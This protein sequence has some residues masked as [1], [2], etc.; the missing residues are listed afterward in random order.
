MEISNCAIPSVYLAPMAGFT[1]R[2][3]REVC[4][5]FFD[6]IITTEMVS[7]SALY[8]GDNKTKVLM[9]GAENQTLQLFGANPEYISRIA[10]IINEH[11][12]NKIEINM[13]C[14]M[15]KIVKN[16]EGS[17]LMKTP[18][19]AARMIE[20]AVIHFN[21]PVGVKFRSG[22][23]EANINAVHFGVV[24]Q[25]AGASYLAVHPR[26]RKQLYTGN[27]DWDIIRQVKENVQIPVIGSGDV[28]SVEDALSMVSETSVDGVMIGRAA[29][30]NPWLLSRVENAFI[31]TEKEKKILAPSVEER[32]SVA[33]NHLNLIIKYKG[34]NVAVREMRKHASYYTRGLTGASQIRNKINLAKSKNEIIDAL[35]IAFL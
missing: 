24:C 26:T 23:D 34:E 16:G 33:K 29:I 17:A 20:Q 9:G 18:E 6:G 31:A 8:Y 13:G 4:R 5:G 7:I 1:D 25:Q 12:A 14:P 32:I 28:K 19:L 35:E 21:K 27:A 30:G 2:A 11:T 3:Y 15:H 10:P 22:W